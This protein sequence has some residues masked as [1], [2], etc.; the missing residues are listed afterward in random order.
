[1]TIAVDLNLS[2]LPPDVVVANTRAKYIEAFE[3]I[4]GETFSWK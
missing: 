4:S 1:M 3:R 2:S